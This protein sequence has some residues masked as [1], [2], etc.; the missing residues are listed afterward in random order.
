MDRGRQPGDVAA[1]REVGPVLQRQRLPGQPRGPGA[2]QGRAGGI[3]G[4]GHQAQR[5]VHAVLGER[6]VHR[7]ELERRELDA[8]DDH[9]QAVQAGH[10]ARWCDADP[11]ELA[12]E[13]LDAEAVEQVD[14]RQVERSRQRV[15]QRDEAGPV[16]VEVARAV[17]AVLRRH[18]G[19]QVLGQR[20]AA[21][22]RQRVEQGLERRARRARPLEHRD[23]AAVRRVEEVQA[24]D[25]R[26]D[27]ARP[28]IDHDDRAAVDALAPQLGP[29]QGD[30][31][32]DDRLRAGVE[33]RAEARPGV[34]AV[35]R[36]RGVRGLA[37]HPQQVVG[38]CGGGGV[39]ERRAGVGRR[40]RAGGDQLAEDRVAP[41][42]QPR[43]AGRPRGVAPG[44]LRHREQ[45][46]DLERRQVARAVAEVR[47]R[48]RLDALDVAAVRRA[49]QVL[50]EDLA[51]GEP[52]IELHGAEHVDELARQRARPR[53]EQPRQLHGQGRA[54]RDPAGVD[55]V[56][57]RGADDRE[58]VDAVVAPEPLVLERDQ[59]R[60]QARVDL[61]ERDRQPPLVVARQEHVGRPA[62]AVLDGDRAAAAARRQ[63]HHQREREQHEQRRVADRGR[64]QRPAQ[65][66]RPPRRA[67]HH[68]RAVISSCRSTAR[69]RRRCRPS[70]APTAWDRTSPR[71]RPAGS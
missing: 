44:P 1:A 18:V 6:G 45:G 70:R 29:A 43:G 51:L 62:V 39:G 35:Q 26:D 30:L 48:G 34:M 66:A 56:A 2:E 20:H 60:D 27:L 7:R 52:Q 38:R 4:A 33:R 5:P 63:R 12:E 25:Q 3:L 41:G 8:A 36:H 17:G 58:R 40:E 19:D 68:A 59:R 14:E 11:A 57:R 13:A 32:L 69:R 54:A 61:V 49:R 71:P 28:V 53:L 50:R 65:P 15:A 46:R 64:P 22:D 37:R 67:S 16:A 10:R 55:G 9:R 21:V 42:A 31:A 23:L 24:A 47:P